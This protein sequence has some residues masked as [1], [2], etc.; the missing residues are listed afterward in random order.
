MRLEQLDHALRAAG[1]VLG[2][3]EFYVAGSQA[4]LGATLEGLP[5]AVMGSIEI[6]L[7][8]VDGDPEKALRL[9]GALG[10]L[11]LFHETHGFYVDGIE[12]LGD[13]LIRLPDGWKSRVVEHRSPATNGVV[14]YCIEPHDVCISKLLAGRE[15]DLVYVKALVQSGHIKPE[16]LLDRLSTTEASDAERDRVRESVRG[17]R[18]AG[19][20]TAFRRAL[21]GLAGRDRAANV[22]VGRTAAG[23][24]RGEGPVAVRCEARNRDRSQ[25]KNRLLPGSRCPVHGWQ[26]PG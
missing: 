5:R 18:K 26:A 7:M 6:D 23:T 24:A 16:V 15:K 2:E 4:L 3:Q 1:A 13:G 14:G 9:N 11:T 17:M 19:R 21:Q 8:P 12:R 20:N 10:E 22:P 25:C